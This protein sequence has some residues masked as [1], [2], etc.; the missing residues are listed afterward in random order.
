VLTGHVKAARRRARA[1]GRPM[2]L[3][4]LLGEIAPA[5][6]RM[7]EEVRTIALHEAAHAVCAHRLGLTVVQVTTLPAGAAAGATILRLSG[8]VPNRSDLE[9]RALAL[10]V[11][12]A[13]DTALG[14]GPNAGAVQDLLEAT[15]VMTAVHAAFGLGETLA[16]RAPPGEA[17]RLLQ[18]DADLH[19]LVEADLQ[20]LMRQAETLVW[21]NR[22][23]ILAVAEAL[24]IRRVLTGNEV[25]AIVAGHP[26][27]LRIRAGS[28]P[29]LA[30]DEGNGPALGPRS[31]A[32]LPSVRGE[33]TCRNHHAPAR[34]ARA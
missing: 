9:R 24:M 13:A 2:I 31:K 26:L 16:H 15:R 7:P 23:A 1:A 30:P 21:A 4:D 17:E 32:D 5:D 28:A 14:A 6:L 10:L 12:R 18:W 19:A 11:G 22:D 20:R 33:P 27:R 29:R 25:A 8:R 34:N 3:E